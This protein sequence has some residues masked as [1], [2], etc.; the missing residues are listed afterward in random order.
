MI[1]T[2]R[3]EDFAAIGALNVLAYSQF[4]PFIGREGW[5]RMQASLRDVATRAERGRFLVARG[6]TGLAAS[7]AYCPPGRSDP[8]IFSSTMASV[9]LLAVHPDAR[10]QGLGREL[11]NAC[12]ACA[13]ADHAGSI[14]LFTSD[15]MLE[16]QRLYRQLGFVRDAELAPRYGVRYFRMTLALTGPDGCIAT[17]P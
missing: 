3:P 1:E 11:M 5:E 7:V 13:R 15:L 6:P 10:G 2:A 4:R 17:G 9:L 8:H 14:S 16:A 12:I